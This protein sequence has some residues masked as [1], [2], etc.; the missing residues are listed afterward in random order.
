MLLFVQIL[1]VCA[2]SITELRLF[3]VLLTGLTSSK[4]FTLSFCYH[5]NMGYLQYNSCTD[6]E[7]IINYITSSPMHRIEYLLVLIA[8]GIYIKGYNVEIIM[9]F[10]QMFRVLY[11]QFSSRFF[12]L[13]SS[14]YRSLTPFTLYM[15]DKSQL[16]QR[17]RNLAPTTRSLNENILCYTL[18]PLSTLCDYE[19]PCR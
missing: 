14:C 4:L 19:N 7:L 1:I 8:D 11:V 6:R 17:Y 18:L 13:W 16:A 12:W 15:K 5:I 10:K 9:L 2:T 3:L